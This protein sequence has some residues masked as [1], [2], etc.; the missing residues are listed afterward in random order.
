MYL[1]WFFFEALAIAESKRS[2]GHPDDCSKE[3]EYWVFL[4]LFV[5]FHGSGA[6]CLTELIWD[7]GGEHFESPESSLRKLHRA[8]AEA[9]VDA[10]ATEGVPFLVL[11]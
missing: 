5:C 9:E 1:F 7:V 6:R 8:L 10:S 11:F 3:N 4:M 2:K